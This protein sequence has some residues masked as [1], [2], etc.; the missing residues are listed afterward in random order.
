MRTACRWSQGVGCGW[1]A[2]QARCY[3]GCDAWCYAGCHA[4]CDAGWCAPDYLEVDD[5][6]EGARPVRQAGAHPERHPPHRALGSTGHRRRRG[7]E[8]A[9][10]EGEGE[11]GEQR[12][13]R[14]APAHAVAR[15][16]RAAARVDV[17]R[18]GGERGWASTQGRG[19]W[20]AREGRGAARWLQRGCSVAA[21]WLQRGCSVAA[22]WR[23]SVARLLL[24]ALRTVDAREAAPLTARRH[25]A[26][27]ARVLASVRVGAPGSAGWGGVGCSQK[28]VGC[29]GLAGS[30]VRSAR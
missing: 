16:A 2:C 15:G 21:V 28:R 14:G 5:A 19:A 18:G 13:Q 3:A 17:L 6:L 20:L 9:R 22:A 30:A 24:R 10:G 4:G 1:A 26:A 12:G 27:A 7:D 23:C 25:A 11:G 29:V 8:A